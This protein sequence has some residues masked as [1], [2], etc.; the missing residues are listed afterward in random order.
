M[1]PQ[2]LRS[3]DCKG[4]LPLHLACSQIEPPA[5]VKTIQILVNGWPESV[6][7]TYFKNSIFESAENETANDA[8]NA[9]DQV[10]Y[11]YNRGY[12]ERPSEELIRL[13]TNDMPP[14]H[15]A[16]TFSAR[17]LTVEYLVMKFRDDLKLFHNGMLP[18]HCA[19]RAGAPHVI[20]NTWLK[21]YP[22]AVAMATTDTGDLPLHCYLSRTWSSSLPD[23]VSFLA[24][25]K[26]LVKQ[27]PA[28]LHQ[29]NRNGYAPFHV[30][31]MNDLPSDVLFYFR[32]AAHT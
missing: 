1:C 19:C 5:P 24:A 12:T 17:K 3:R 26:Y 10:C 15:F 21:P 7:E 14:L 9:L 4:R 8:W 28:A 20:L 25:V 31:E 27:Y 18:I 22:E 2:A 32:G 16:A 29:M 11:F 6:Q 23:S 13:L 30:P